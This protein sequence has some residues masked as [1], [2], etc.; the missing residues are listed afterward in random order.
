M[1]EPVPPIDDELV[2]AVLDGE[3]TPAE[4]ALVEG[5][6]AGRRRLEQ[7]RATAAAVGEPVEP[8][9]P[10]VVDRLVGRALDE[11]LRS[12]PASTLSPMAR[13]SRRR[14]APAVAAAAAA[15]LAVGGIVAL[16]R[17]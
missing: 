14:W 7:L 10:A 5:S 8:L 12:E 11:N 16:A 3:A 6:P 13:P 1:T 15:I 9:S 4:R 2:S 17:S